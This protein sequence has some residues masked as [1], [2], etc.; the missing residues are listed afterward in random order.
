M[1]HCLQ[2]MSTFD[3]L[4]AETRETVLTQHLRGDVIAA[5]SLG[6]GKGAEATEKLWQERSGISVADLL[7]QSKAEGG[8]G[9]AAK[10]LEHITDEV[11]SGAPPSFVGS[12][13]RFVGR[14]TLISLLWLIWLQTQKTK[15]VHIPDA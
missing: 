7:Q 5:T 2:D 11:N 12:N 8:S 14:I 10:V 15:V 13:D 6:I 1:S 4:N 9:A 3:M